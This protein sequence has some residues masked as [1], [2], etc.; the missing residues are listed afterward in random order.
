MMSIEVYHPRWYYHEV[1]TT[2]EI[3]T[4]NEIFQDYIEDDNN[5][6][7]PPGWNCNVQTSYQVGENDTPEWKEFLNIIRPYVDDMLSMV[8]A[9]AVEVL[10]QEAWVNKYN[11]G[12]SQELHDHCTPN[13]N[14]SMVYF[15]RLNDD[16]NCQFKFKDPEHS[17]YMMEGLADLMVLPCE[18]YHT[19]PV[20]QGSIIFFPSHYPHLVSPHR[21]TQTRITFSANFYLVPYGWRG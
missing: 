19:P 14:L 4:I 13:T 10:P 5:F 2:T 9:K 16:D 21:G 6:K 11:P 8:R 20:K 12:D 1:L 17:N 3:S 18:Q 7:Q 15:H